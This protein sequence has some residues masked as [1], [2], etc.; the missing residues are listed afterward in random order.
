MS[1]VTDSFEFGWLQELLNKFAA[2][3]GFDL[4]R[5]CF[6]Q[7]DVSGPMMASMLQPLSKPAQLYKLEPMK[8]VFD[9]CVQKAL[10]FVNGQFPLLFQ[11][12]HICRGLEPVEI[13][14]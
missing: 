9:P 7:D 8:Q 13:S 10:Q 4:M 1:E 14:R 2:Q 5:S 6:L 11:I 3:R 12:H